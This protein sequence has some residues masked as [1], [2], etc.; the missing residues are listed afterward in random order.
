MC[1]VAEAGIEDGR[2]SI[3]SSARSIASTA[4]SRAGS[5]SCLEVRL[6]DLDYVGAGCLEIVQLLVDCRRVRQCETP[7]VVVVVVLCLLRHRERAWHGDLDVPVGDRPQEL[8]VPDIDRARAAD[9]PR[10]ARDGVRVSG[11]V[12]SDSRLVEIDAVERGREPV[13]IALPAHLAVRHHVDSGSLHVGHSQ[14]RRVVLGLFEMV[15]R[16]APQLECSHA[17]RQ[18]TPEPFAIDQPVRLR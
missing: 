1:G 12:E 11:P 13:R 9:R 7:G 4:Y 5:R 2:P 16:D 10:D 8:D 18:A 15:C 14:P 3:P 6:V 17:R